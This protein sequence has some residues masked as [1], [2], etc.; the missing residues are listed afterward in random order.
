MSS[1]FVHLHLHSEYSLVDGLV[2]VKPLV[3][4]VADA[5]M[6]AVAVTDQCN[7]FAMV[8]FYRAALTTGVKPVI[9][10]D[11]L[12]DSSQEGGQPDALIL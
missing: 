9:G 6:P 4:A 7:L 8:K 5:G 2:R 1:Q 12:L 10:V 11:V 3:Q